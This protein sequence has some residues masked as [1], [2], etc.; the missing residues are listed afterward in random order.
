MT[1]NIV[2]AAPSSGHGK[3][4]ISCALLRYFTNKGFRVQAFKAGP[5]FIDTQYHNCAIKNKNKLHDA[6][7]NLDPFAMSKQEIRY[8]FHQFTIDK[9][10][11]IIEGV[12]GLF[13]GPL[14]QE[15]TTA[16]LA[17]ILDIPVVLV[18]DA[19]KTGQSIAATYFG[20]THYDPAIRVIGYIVNRVQSFRHQKIIEQALPQKDVFNL[21]LYEDKNFLAPSRHL[22]LVQAV[23]NKKLDEQCDAMASSL[24]Q[25]ISHENFH[26]LQQHAVSKAHIYD[27]QKPSSFLFAP[28]VKNKA[29]PTIAVAYDEAFQFIYSHLLYYWH[30]HGVRIIFFSPIRNEPIAEEAQILF[31]PGGY[32]EIYAKE[33]TRS[34]IFLDS[35]QSFF[36]HKKPIYAECGGFMTLGKSLIDLNGE[37]HHMSDIVPIDFSMHKQKNT[38]GM[39]VVKHEEAHGFAPLHS[40]LYGHEYHKAIAKKSSQLQY[41]Q[42]HDSAQQHCT[43][44]AFRSK[45][46]F[47]SFFHFISSQPVVSKS[48]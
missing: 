16:M 39:R 35:L 2:I 47:A 46:I 43:I 14:Q 22:G 21:F 15:S 38:L 48:Y 31:L 4:M 26:F 42:A 19:R 17:K 30:T 11:A 34:H 29:S 37:T 27:G 44:Q 7:I 36:K 40:T 8:L 18:M 45:H 13:D 6:S 1:I 32:P 3:T 10:I 12:M 28:L 41:L 24:E 20:F 25:A 23:E 33:I 5:D 9:D